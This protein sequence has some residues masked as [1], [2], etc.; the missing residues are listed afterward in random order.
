[1]RPFSREEVWVAVKG[2][3]SEG[4]PG[5]DGL[6]VF[7]FDEFGD[8][9]EADVMGMLEKFRHC[10]TDLD[11][12]NKSHLFL[13]P[14]HAGAIRVGNYPP[15]AL[16]NSI[17]LILAETLAN[18]MQEVIGTV[19]GPFQSAFIP[20]R[21]LIDSVLLAGEI[22]A[23]WQRKGTKGSKWKVDFSKAYD[24]IS[25]KFLRA[26]IGKQGFPHT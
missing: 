15:I 21:H 18:R 8:L 16:S 20:R 22:V 6:S 12:P 5:S 1:M 9:T 19:V 4:A 23:S 24:T 25:W 7:F 26:S 3:N 13:L 11:R 14:K 17:Y 2:L 10:T